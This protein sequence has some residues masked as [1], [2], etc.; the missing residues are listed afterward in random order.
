MTV[1]MVKAYNYGTMVV[2]TPGDFTLGNF[3]VPTRFKCSFRLHS[4]GVWFSFTLVSSVVLI[5]TRFECSFNLHSFRV[6]FCFA[7]VSSV[8]FKVLAGWNG[9]ETILVH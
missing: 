6:W 3:M 1:N 4:F 7:L 5:Y 8:V 9:F 2:S